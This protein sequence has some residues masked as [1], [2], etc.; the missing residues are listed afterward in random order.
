MAIKFPAFSESFQPKYLR[1]YP[2]SNSAMACGAPVGEI[3]A[4][5]RTGL[6]VR[7][8]TWADVAAMEQKVGKSSFQGLNVLTELKVEQL[9]E[10]VAS[11]LSANEPAITKELVMAVGASE[12]PKFAEVAVAFL[13]A[14]TLLP[15]SNDPIEPSAPA[16][17]TNSTTDVS[18][19]AVGC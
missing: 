9:A 17:S 15:E 19:T 6:K 12:Y 4:F 13:W 11:A 1:L 5:G 7:C 10:V 16:S 3:D 14:G 18:R 8:A 2:A